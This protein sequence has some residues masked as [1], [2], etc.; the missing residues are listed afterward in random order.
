MARPRQT[1]SSFSTRACPLCLVKDPSHGSWPSTVIHPLE[2][3]W[4]W[5]LSVWGNWEHLVLYS[6]EQDSVH[7]VSGPSWT[8]WQPALE[9]D[10]VEPSAVVLQ[11]LAQGCP[12]MNDIALWGPSLY[13]AT[14]FL[15]SEGKAGELE[16]GK[17]S[18]HF[19]LT[20]LLSVV[21]GVEASW[22][23]N[24]CRRHPIPKE[25]LRSYLCEGPGHLGSCVCYLMWP[26]C[27]PCQ[28][29]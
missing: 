24:L 29:F 4:L 6:G 25:N 23:D 17:R 1:A 3:P 20:P 21:E 27:P 16:P 19:S 15:V 10:K 11:H 8:V 18:T 2:V 12:A 14:A 22:G 28:G 5:P 13:E 26:P 7:L 9:G